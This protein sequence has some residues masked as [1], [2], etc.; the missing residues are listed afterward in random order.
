MQGLHMTRNPDCQCGCG[1]EVRLP[2]NRFIVGHGAKWKRALTDEDAA[3]ARRMFGFGETK[4][5]IAK[6]FRISLVTLK[7]RVFTHGYMP[8]AR[9]EPAI[10]Q[11]Q[12]D[13]RKER[14]QWWRGRKKRNEIIRYLKNLNHSGSQAKASGREQ[15]SRT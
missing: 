4:A 1:L 2:T 5:A 13:A 8:M 10:R 3:E 6:H 14:G 12:V 9:P 11:P 7:V 15:T